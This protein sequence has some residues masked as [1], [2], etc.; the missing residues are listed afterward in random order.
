MVARSAAHVAVILVLTAGLTGCAG[1]SSLERGVALY[2][3]GHYA[4]ARDVFDDFLRRYPDSAAAYVD[5]GVT[6]IR[7]GNDVR[8]S[9]DVVEHGLAADAA[10]PRRVS[11]HRGLGDRRPRAR[12]ARDR[13][14]DRRRS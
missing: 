13:P 3:T 8:I 6:R 1:N 10:R 9:G 5:R 2:R 14:R 11:G 12:H 7:L 4:D